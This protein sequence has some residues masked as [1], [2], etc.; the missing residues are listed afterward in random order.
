MLRW[1][2]R[3]W[4]K[5]RFID[6]TFYVPLI[7]FQL[8]VYTSDFLKKQPL[9]IFIFISLSI[10]SNNFIHFWKF[11]LKTNSFCHKIVKNKITLSFNIAGWALLQCVRPLFII[12]SGTFKC[13]KNWSWQS[14][15]TSCILHYFSYIPE[16]MQS[17]LIGYLTFMDG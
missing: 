2:F 16:R 12:C 7:F 11:S 6:P 3:I 9:I 17:R 15:G 4:K 5:Y 1:Q 8:S 13:Y 10:G 14:Y